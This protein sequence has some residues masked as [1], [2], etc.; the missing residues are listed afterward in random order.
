[1]KNIIK[2]FRYVV[3]TASDRNQKIIIMFDEIE[4]IS[5]KSPW[6][7]I[8]RQNLLIF[9]KLSGPFKASIET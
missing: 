5:F 2:S 6:T 9:G 1:M 3:K 8:G 4:Y 7:H